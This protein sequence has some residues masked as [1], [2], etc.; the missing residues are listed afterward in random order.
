MIEISKEDLV[1]IILEDDKTIEIEEEFW[2]HDITHYTI[3]FYKHDK[4]Y[5]LTYGCSYNY[6]IDDGPFKAYEAESFQKVTTDWRI[7]KVD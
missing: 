3:I 1:D 2:K 6:G 5:M 7:K 4:P